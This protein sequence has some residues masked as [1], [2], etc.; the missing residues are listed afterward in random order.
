MD[1]GVAIDVTPVYTLKAL[2]ALGI[3]SYLF[4]LNT[5][6]HF[7]LRIQNNGTRSLISYGHHNSALYS[8]Y[9]IRRFFAVYSD[10]L[11]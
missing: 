1:D 9:T 6:K 11:M 4:I 8:I 7:G 3:Y 10:V 5:T 2:R